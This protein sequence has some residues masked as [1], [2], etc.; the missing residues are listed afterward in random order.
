MVRAL[1]GD[2]NIL[3]SSGLDSSLR[4]DTALS[5]GV[6]SADRNQSTFEYSSYTVYSTAAVTMS[7]ACKK[8]QYNCS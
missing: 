8:K 4:G 7:L 2:R 5:L 3:S 6:E 1:V